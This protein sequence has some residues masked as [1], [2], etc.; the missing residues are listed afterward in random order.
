MRL[1][2]HQFTGFCFSIQ[3]CV[4]TGQASATHY[5]QSSIMGFRLSIL[6]T[7]FAVLTKP[8]AQYFRFQ[9]QTGVASEGSFALDVPSG[10]TAL[11]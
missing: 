3:R 9:S 2:A 4:R 11:F 6:V 1:P 7:R 5:E 8:L 10:L